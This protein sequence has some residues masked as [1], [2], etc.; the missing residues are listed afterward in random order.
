MQ[1][2]RLPQTGMVQ[3]TTDRA[4]VT[5]LAAIV[6]HTDRVCRQGMTYGAGGACAA[7][8]QL[9][10]AA[11]CHDAAAPQDQDAVA[12]GQVVPLVSHQQPCGPL[13]GGCLSQEQPIALCQ[14]HD[15]EQQAA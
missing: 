8:L 4:L 13:Q 6:P 15:G 5:C 7:H 9:L 3:K 14:S 1:G 12:A 10:E 2:I 11:V